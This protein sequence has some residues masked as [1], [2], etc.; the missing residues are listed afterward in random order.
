MNQAEEKLET[1]QQDVKKLQ[2][3]IRLLIRAI[4][5][6]ASRSNE[7]HAGHL[8]WEATKLVGEEEP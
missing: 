6:L 1:L 8:A 2:E 7:R 5:T 4:E 3:A